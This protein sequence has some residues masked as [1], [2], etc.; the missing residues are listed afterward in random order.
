MC[1]FDCLFS[2]LPLTLNGFQY[3]SCVGSIL[4]TLPAT[5]E[6]SCF[7][8]SHVSVRWYTQSGSAIGN[9]FQYISCVGSIRWSGE[10]MQ[11]SIGFNTSHV[12]VRYRC[13]KW[14][15][16]CRWVSIHLMCRF[17]VRFCT[18][19]SIQKLVSIHLMCRFDHHGH[20]FDHYAMLVSIHLMCRFDISF[21]SS[22]FVIYPSFNTS[23]VSV[24]FYRC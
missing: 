16:Y 6:A 7:N 11:L 22:P 17:D 8:T 10:Q 1:R 4:E 18:L 21:I 24:R 14:E 20:A 13:R 2:D 5:I 19:K 15:V 23:H 3:I 12:S 9:T